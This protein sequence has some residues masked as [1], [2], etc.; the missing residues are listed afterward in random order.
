MNSDR[1][2]GWLTLAAN[3]GVIV[4]LLLL[5]F[6]INQS[7]R[8]TIAAASEGL[9]GHSLDFMAAR[10]DND[11]VAL[12]S[13][14]ERQ[15]L[16]LEGIESHQLE[17]LQHLN[18]RLFESAYLQHERGFFEQTEWERYERI[19]AELMRDDARA[20]A[21]WARTEGGWTDEFA[22]EVER[23]RRAANSDQ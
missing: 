18:F 14:K 9:T 19:I 16:A 2:H 21:M 3:L 11:I 13:F 15:G 1:T 20:Q 17:L 5:A 8:A 22:E 6:E 12:A 4:S 23:I 7:T 10:L